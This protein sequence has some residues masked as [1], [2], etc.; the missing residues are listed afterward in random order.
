MKTALFVWESVVFNVPGTNCVTFCDCQCCRCLMRQ[1]TCGRTTRR[2]ACELGL[3][4]SETETEATSLRTLRRRLL[5][6]WVSSSRLS[7]VRTSVNQTP[8]VI[9]TSIGCELTQ[10]L[11]QTCSW[12]HASD[13]PTTLVKCTKPTCVK[14]ARKM[15]TLQVVLLWTILFQN[16]LLINNEKMKK[17]QQTHSSIGPWKSRYRGWAAARNV[18]LHLTASLS[19]LLLLPL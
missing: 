6:L 14:C 16:S 11:A 3:S 18:N 15:Q 5:C 17:I 19:L 13:S 1:K 10:L 8:N 4:R 9:R 7:Q 2:K 12:K